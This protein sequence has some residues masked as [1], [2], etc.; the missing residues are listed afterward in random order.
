MLGYYQ[1]PEKTFAVLKDGWL[2]TG[3]IAII[4]DAGF[5]KIKGRNDDLIIKSGINVYPAEIEGILKQD[6]RVKEVLVYGYQD[7][8]STQIGIKLAG[9]FSTVEEI[10]Q[11]CT[12]TLS[13]FQIPS[14]IELVCELPKN[15]SGKVMRRESV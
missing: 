15:A 11:L 12:K 14:R 4:N 5:L 8:I 1:E 6:A 7:S 2:C 3:D 10:K 13:S 9:D